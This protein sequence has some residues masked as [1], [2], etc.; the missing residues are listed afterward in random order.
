ML[1]SLFFYMV[2]GILGVQLFRGSLGSCSD[3]SIDNKQDCYGTYTIEGDSIEYK[4]KWIIPYNN[5]DDV[6]K[7]MVT[8]FEISTLEMW[9][10][11]MWAAIDSRGYG[12]GPKKNARVYNAAI[13]VI[14]IFITTFFVMNLFISVIVDRFNEEIRKKE[15]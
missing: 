12:L 1:I 9:P 14:F 15:G 11:N 10:D 5:Y 6:M 13:F 2:F 7:S 4:R 8:F 3:E